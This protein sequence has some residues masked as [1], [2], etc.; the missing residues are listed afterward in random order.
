MR[1]FLRAIRLLLYLPSRWARWSHRLV[2]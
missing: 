2:V 1:W